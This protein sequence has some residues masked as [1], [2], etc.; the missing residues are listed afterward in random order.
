MQ[1]LTTQASW[2]ADQYH[3]MIETGILDDG[4]IKVSKEGEGINH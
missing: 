1:L 3:R 2:T 4:D